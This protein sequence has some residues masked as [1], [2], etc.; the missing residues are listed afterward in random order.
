MSEV[1][2]SN[3]ATRSR[4]F[5]R[6]AKWVKARLCKSRHREFDSHHALLYAEMEQER[7]IRLITVKSPCA[8]HGSAIPEVSKCRKEVAVYSERICQSMRF[9]NVDV[10]R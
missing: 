5:A 4:F 7:L 10:G 9:C 1:A 8:I 3:L 2:S 6:V